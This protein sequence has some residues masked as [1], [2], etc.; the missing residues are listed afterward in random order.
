VGE[1]CDAGFLDRFEDAMEVE[2]YLLYAVAV[3]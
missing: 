1:L 3:V 2:A